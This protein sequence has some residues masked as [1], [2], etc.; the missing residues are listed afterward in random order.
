MKQT[1]PNGQT[2]WRCDRCGIQTVTD[3]GKLP[4]HWTTPPVTDPAS[5]PSH[6]CGRCTLAT[7]Q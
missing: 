2:Q 1:Y 6:L 3:I 7:R 4:Y 5:T